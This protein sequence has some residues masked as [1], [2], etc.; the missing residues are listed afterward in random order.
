MSRA[1][2]VG[3]A[4]VLRRARRPSRRLWTPEDRAP[5]Y[6]GQWSSR[7]AS[8]ANL[9]VNDNVPS[10][11]GAGAAPAVAHATG[12]QRPKRG[13]LAN[14]EPTV[15][16]DGV[17]DM[18]YTSSDVVPDGVTSAWV[19]VVGGFTALSGTAA[20]NTLF[21][22]G[23][24]NADGGMVGGAQYPSTGVWFEGT[25]SFSGSTPRGGTSDL[26]LHTF[27]FLWDLV[28]NGGVKLWVDGA[29]QTMTK[30]GNPGFVAAAG[31]SSL[32]AC[33]VFGSSAGYY[34]GACRLMRV[35]YGF[36]WENPSANDIAASAAYGARIVA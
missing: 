7:H 29:S 1:A 5:G 35:V 12:G 15:D 3:L 19:L 20:P 24:G 30:P 16:F 33:N 32:G 14:G 27:L 22:L 13:V 4:R 23:S 18:L 21:N 10:W 8:V 6:A 9:A 25:T 36:G 31:G 2:D 11:T 34:H 28:A 17:D 26:S